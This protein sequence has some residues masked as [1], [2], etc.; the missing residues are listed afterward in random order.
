MFTMNWPR[1]IKPPRR[2]DFPKTR[3]TTW[4]PDTWGVLLHHFDVLYPNMDTES[5]QTVNRMAA[6]VVPKEPYFEW[7]RSVLGDDSDNC[8]PEVFRSVFLIPEHN[9]SERALRGS[10]A[11]IFEEMLE[12]SVNGMEF[13]PA[14]RDLRTFRKWFDVQ[15]VEMVY[16]TSEGEL[17][18]DQI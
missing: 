14:K 3:R 6:I 5:M 7:S 18:H 9:D 16:D 1:S 12:A 8:G 11:L 13:W 15:V 17:L 2:R 10:F 4:S